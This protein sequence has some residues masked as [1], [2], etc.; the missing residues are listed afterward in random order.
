MGKVAGSIFSAVAAVAALALYWR[1]V[2]T[3]RH[4]LL[5]ALPGKPEVSW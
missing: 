5:A 4:D 1:E 2:R 3:S